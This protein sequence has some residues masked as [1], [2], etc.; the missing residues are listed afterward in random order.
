M[1]CVAGEPACETWLHAVRWALW[2]VCEKCEFDHLTLLHLPSMRV[3]ALKTGFKVNFACCTGTRTKLTC[4][5]TMSL[6][7]K[8]AGFPLQNLSRCVDIY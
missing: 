5:S 1:W 4:A 7:R 3:K 8:L 2:L 6:T